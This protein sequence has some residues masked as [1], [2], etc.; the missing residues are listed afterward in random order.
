MNIDTGRPSLL[1]QAID[2]AYEAKDAATKRFPR[3]IGASILGD[4]CERK[5]W[6][7]FFWGRVEHHDGQK[8][9][10]FETG[11]I[12]EQ[13][14]LEQLRMIGVVL[15]ED[16]AQHAFTAVGGHVVAKIDGYIV[17]GLPESPKTEHILE[18]KSSNRKRFTPLQKNGV[19]K[20]EPKHYAQLVLPMA[21]AG[22]Q[23]GLY[24]S[25]RKDDDALYTERVEA[26][27][28]LAEELL[29]KAERIIASDRPP[30]RI[31]D[32]PRTF[33]CT[34]CTYTEECHGE[35]LPPPTCRSCT[36][37]IAV[38]TGDDGAWYCDKHEAQL[39]YD[40]QVKGCNQHL[41]NPTILEHWAEAIDADNESVLYEYKPK[42]L[43][44]TNG[45]KG[46][47]TY[48]SRELYRLAHK[49]ALGDTLI[50]CLR[51]EFNGEIVG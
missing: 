20:A 42:R 4:D 14:V 30:A 34:F 2:A 24:V 18:I 32:D 33:P 26:N 21:L 46:D 51:T 39:S 45:P 15:D 13:R 48:T 36:H 27:D 23:R 11:D 5:V 25:Q 29:A 12:V 35:S 40:D 7:N 1:V 31:K 50:K 43:A 22:V 49:G 28:R 37:A 41:Y 9:R 8:L 44:F 6:Y 10:L 47:D 16:W 3:R 38:M 19:A 17:S